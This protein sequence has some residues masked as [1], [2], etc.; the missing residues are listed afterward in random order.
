[1]EPLRALNPGRA[2]AVRGWV[3]RRGMRQSVAACRSAVLGLSE[4][5]GLAAY[6]RVEGKSRQDY[7]VIKGEALQEPGPAAATVCWPFWPM[8]SPPMSA[9]DRQRRPVV[10]NCSYSGQASFGPSDYR[11]LRRLPIQKRVVV[12]R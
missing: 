2:L 12:S 5:P 8:R 1:V 9:T 6:G 7:A 11:R 10:C 3:F 4:P